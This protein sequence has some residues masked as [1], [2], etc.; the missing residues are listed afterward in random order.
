MADKAVI[1]NPKSFLGLTKRPNVWLNIHTKTW[2]KI[3]QK[4]VEQGTSLWRKQRHEIKVNTYLMFI[5][6][7]SNLLHF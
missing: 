5:F 6:L 1:T 4:L 2:H 7:N 3:L